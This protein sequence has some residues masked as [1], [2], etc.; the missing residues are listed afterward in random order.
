VLWA[1][2]FAPSGVFVIGF[3]TSD[4]GQEHWVVRKRAAP[5]PA[6]LAQALRQELTDLTARSA[7]P[8]ARANVLLSTLDRLVAEMEQGQSALACNSLSTFSKKIQQFVNQ[9]ILA[10]S[11]A[12]LLINGTANLS[13]TLGCQE[14]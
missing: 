1:T 6:E 5:S 8:R 11:D 7:I 9:G 3:G 4:T 14:K 2:T 12:E 10:Q 13:Q